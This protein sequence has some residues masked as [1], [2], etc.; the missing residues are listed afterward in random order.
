MKLGRKLKKVGQK[1][2]VTILLFYKKK[3]LIGGWPMSKGVKK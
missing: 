1:K 2:D 3:E